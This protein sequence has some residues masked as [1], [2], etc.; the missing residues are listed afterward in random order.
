MFQVA[1]YIP[2]NANYALTWYY[3]VG[4]DLLQNMFICTYC[5]LSLIDIGLRMIID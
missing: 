1:L 3:Y 4:D 5:Y 2:R